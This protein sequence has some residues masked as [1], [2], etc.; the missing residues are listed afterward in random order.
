LVNFVTVSTSRRI[1]LIL[2]IVGE[3]VFPKTTTTML[4]YVTFCIVAWLVITH[5]GGGK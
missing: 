3:S 2:L 5:A 1:Y 4:G